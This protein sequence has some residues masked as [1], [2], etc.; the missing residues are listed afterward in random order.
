M[1]SVATIHWPSIE[2]TGLKAS[3]AGPKVAPEY[4]NPFF[5][6]PD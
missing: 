4:N 3:V 1:W 5:F 2:V 6:T